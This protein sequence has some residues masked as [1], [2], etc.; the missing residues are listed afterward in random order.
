MSSSSDPSTACASDSSVRVHDWDQ[1]RI[2]EIGMYSVAD[3]GINRGGL[4]SFVL[5]ALDGDSDEV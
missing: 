2:I 3:S 4:P 1:S 5:A